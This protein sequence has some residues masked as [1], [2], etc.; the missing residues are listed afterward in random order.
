MTT[1][2]ERLATLSYSDSDPSLILT[3]WCC[4]KDDR[5][6]KGMGKRGRERGSITGKGLADGSTR[7]RLT[8]RS[9]GKGGVGL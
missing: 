3:I 7:F 4:G 9:Y 5:E 1:E 8:I 6:T 2:R